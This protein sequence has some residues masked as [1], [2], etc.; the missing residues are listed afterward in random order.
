MATFYSCRCSSTKMMKKLQVNTPKRINK[1]PKNYTGS[2]KD[3]YFLFL[4]L[5]FYYDDEEVI[6]WYTNWLSL[7]LNLSTL[8]ASQNPQKCSPNF[9]LWKTDYF[10]HNGAKKSLIL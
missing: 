10:S 9:S 6:S 3:G 7:S 5:Q 1:T 4:P 2:P 8:Q